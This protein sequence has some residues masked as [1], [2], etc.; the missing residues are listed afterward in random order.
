MNSRMLPFET[1]APALRRHARHAGAPDRVDVRDLAGLIWRRRRV[2]LGSMAAGLILALAAAFVMTPKYEAVSK[3]MLDSRVPQMTSPTQVVQDPALND[4]VVNSSV[5]VIESNVLIGRAIDRIGM[6][7]LAAMDPANRPP[8]LVDRAKAWVEGLLPKAPAGPSL[9]SPEQAMRERLSWEIVKNLKVTREDQSNVLDIS[10][11]NRDRVLAT[12]LSNA[13]AAEFIQSQVAAR[14]AQAGE[15]TKGLEDRLSV[16]KADVEK[17][18]D[19]VDNYRAAHL[20]TDGGTLDAATQQL[21]QLN[22]Q[23]VLARA[24]RIQ[25]EAAYNRLADVVAKQGL[26]GVGQL[27]SSPVLDQLNGQL[28]DLQRQDGIWV[29]QGYPPTHPERMRLAT[30][31][32]GVQGDIAA[33]VQKI[34]EQKKSDLATA[35]LREQTMQQSIA[36]MEARVVELSQSTI[37][38][39]QLQRVADSARQAYDGLLTRVNDSRTEAQMQQ[40]DAQLIEQ[41]T[42][43]SVPASPRTMLMAAVGGLLGLAIGFG[44]VLFQELTAP[45]FAHAADL[46]E[47]TGLPVLAAIPEGDWRSPLGAWQE[48]AAKPYGLYAERIRHLRTAL[49]AREGMAEPRALLLASSVPDEGKTTT[50]L[51]LA[52]M[53][54]LAGRRVV[55]VDGDLRR[56][57]L[58]QT[59]GWDMPHDF[60]DF[61]ANT[62]SLGEAIHR[63]P[64][65]GFDVL[66]A[67]RPRPDAADELSTAWLEPMIASLKGAYD[68]VLVDAPAA[69]AVADA[70]VLAQAVDECLYLVRWRSTP[71]QGVA[72][73]LAQFAEAGLAVSGLVLTQVD[74]KTGADVYA[75]DY[76]YSS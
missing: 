17:A 66:A 68:L 11:W 5:T 42:Y 40:P 61:I 31:I 41:A 70:L 3:V 50:A 33:E 67:R 36:A 32:K 47:A 30:E 16:M 15:A 8:G 38:L 34:V 25:A 13:L 76:D 73:G 9:L 7:K 21:G 12:Q 44:A 1:A 74:P 54:A 23:L 65:L 56:A 39:R 27:V 52:R 60:A 62:C 46:E 71:R 43:P 19:A 29:A 24:D 20:I 72:K 35:T 51:S 26:A 63:D 4:Q 55:L 10:V 64:A 69:L 75:G 58:S 53:A 22:N 57:S 28:M 14:Q 59:F 48:L 45:S 37:G 18:E 49:L 6:D 2:V